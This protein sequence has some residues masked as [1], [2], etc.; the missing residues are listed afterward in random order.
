MKNY[1]IEQIKSYN[2]RISYFN[3]ITR[4]IKTKCKIMF[5]TF[6]VF[7]SIIMFLI[8]TVNTMSGI[9]SL[10]A[11][12]IWGIPSIKIIR[13]EEKQI[14]KKHYPYALNMDGSFKPNFLLEI[15]KRE[16]IKLLGS[17]FVRK[18]SL[19][20][21][22]NKI[23]SHSKKYSYGLAIGVFSV[24]IA[25]LSGAFLSKFLD[26]AND[27]SDFLNA[28]KTL[29]PIGFFY[30][31]LLIIVDIFAIRPLVIQRDNNRNRLVRT[32]ENI[33]WEKFTSNSME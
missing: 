9:F 17:D 4:K 19:N 3:L 2:D 12:I 18:D 24:F 31:V 22:I 7:L 10:I 21:L 6:I 29:I 15:Q 5:L 25:I 32:M 26:F 27:M 11:S 20:F 1:Y 14:I 28:S 16:F 8:V 33:Y 30:T 23:S 13:N